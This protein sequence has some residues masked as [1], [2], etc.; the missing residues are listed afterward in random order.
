VAFPL[1]WWMLDKKGNSNTKERVNLLDEFVELFCEYKIA[2]LSAE[3]E[4]LGCDWL[5]YLL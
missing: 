3:R 5:D 2:Y 4:F 1:L